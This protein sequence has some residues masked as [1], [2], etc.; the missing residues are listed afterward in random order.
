M[1]QLQQYYDSDNY[2]GYQFV[3]LD[4]IINQFMAVYV[5]EEKLIA[6]AS[7][8]DVAFHAQR[9]TQELSFDTFKSIGSQEFEVPS[10][11]TMPLPYDYVNYTQVSWTDG[12]GIKHRLYPAAK[13]SNPIN[14]Y[15]NDDKEFN[16]TAIGDLVNTSSDIVLDGEYKN[17]RVGMVV[18][19]P[20]I[21]ANTIVSATANA[22]SVTT[23][24]ITDRLDNLVNP[25]QTNTNTKLTFYNATDGFPNGDLIL[26]EKASH[27]VEN[28]SWE[29]NDFKI[30]ASSADDITD[31][32]IGMLVS[33]NNFPI[34]T[35]VTNVDGTTIV[36]SHLPDTQGTSGGEGTFMDTDS[37]S[38]TWGSYKSGTPSESNSYDYTDDRY[39]PLDG[40]RFGLDPQH[41][42][43]NGSFYIDNSAGKIHFSSNI[44]GKTVVIDY[45]SDGLHTGAYELEVEGS[46]PG[47]VAG[48]K[49]EAMT[50]IYKS[51]LIHKFAEEA[52]YKWIAYGILSGRANIPE[53]IIQRL[54][55]ERFAETRKAKLR[56]SNIKLE[57]LTQILRGKSKW[58]KH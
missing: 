38:D 58:I 41:S 56:L 46:G 8:V 18:T 9:A 34:G 42:Q 33:H 48:R 3:S 43:T 1:A 44:S 51:P 13:T 11:L 52:M 21:P 12:L 55:K 28:L 50:R 45:I 29:T 36:T 35:T 7:R 37:E 20:Y 2:G 5:G 24:T 4:D 31:I 6:K 47:G 32:K 22:S 27:V 54:K 30:T 49:D 16:L 40:S 14:P 25:S 19:G 10:T 15:Q 26:K 23:I 57:E 17:I 53:F 39:W